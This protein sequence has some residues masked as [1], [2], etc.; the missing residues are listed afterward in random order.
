MKR[1][2]PAAL[3]FF[4]AFLL[5]VSLFSCKQA[6]TKN[7]S[8]KDSLAIRKEY[9]SSPV[10]SPDES[11]KQIQ[12]EKG[13]TVKLV[14]SEPVVNS[15]VALTFDE[16][17]R[18]WVAEML[19]YMPDTV[20][21]G[22]ERPTGKI[23]I[24]SDRNGDGVMD[25]QKMFLDSL[26]LPRAL[27]L[28]DNGILVAESPKLWFYEIENDRPVKKTLVDSAYAEGGNVE[29]QPN[30]LL[31]ALDNWIYNAK[32]AKRYRK[33]GD[34][35]LIER[36]H[37]RGQW[38]ITQDD[39][40][41][42][43]YN[44]NSENLLG[45][46]FTPGVG[47]YNK[48]QPQVAGFNENIV[49]DNRVYPIRPNTG[50]NRGY[51]EGILNSSLRLV[52]FTAACGPAYYDAPLFGKDFYGSVFVAEPSANLIKRDVL[53]D[54]GYRVEGKQAYDNREFL[55][56][57]DERFRPVSLYEG[58][59]GA[60]YVADMYRGI[61]QH[62][63]FLTGYLKN[64][65]KERSLTLP[66]NYGRI[67][68]VVPENAKVEKVLIDKDP[69][70]LVALLGSDNGWI[71]NKAQQLLIDGKFTQIEPDVRNLLKQTNKPLTLIHALWA[72]EGLNVLQGGD[73]LPLLQQA[74]WTIRM[75]A[76]SVLPS[77][78]K[79]NNFG[80]FLRIFDKMIDANDTLAAPY[81][82]FLAHSIKPYDPNAA[83]RI[84]SALIKK[85][86]SNIYVADAVIS[87]LE[88]KENEY[89]KKLISSPADTG[90]AIV[91]RLKLVIENIAKTKNKARMKEVEK[92]FPKGAALFSSTCQPCH[93]SDGNGVRALGPPLNNSNWVLGDK[94]K[95][96]PIVLFGLTGPV[97]V[98]DKLYK[99]PEVSGEMPAIGQNKEFTDEDIAQVLSF[100]RNGWNNKAAPIKA[101]DVVNAR[102]KF[103]GR[104]K[105]FTPD[106]LDK[107]R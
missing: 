103:K 91:K 63:A 48:N 21:T 72:M 43:F 3:F 12:A 40:G 98:G 10:L 50:V 11:L 47:A 36:T 8:E 95:L 35:W 17:G 65:I 93:G 81:L 39:Q 45:D 77:I 69:R 1:T 32:S 80:Q 7:N 70:Q 58:P 37:F 78:L 97:K 25:E 66:L 31:R 29:H 22:E 60:L 4:A 75:Q 33:Q 64:E 51:M 94:N 9:A 20:G 56:S 18:I 23:V 62:K 71:R 96:L 73:V 61:I 6:S 106:E 82:G 15:P 49:P 59:D 79:T 87:N 90:L 68:K 28:I 13:F 27:C 57:K 101:S 19:S 105:S 102:N 92:Q 16:K 34:K 44:T 46:Y 2:T 74:D 52:N 99:A 107:L 76:L 38:G 26:V 104:Q 84:L 88:N 41:R 14:A 89:L 54:V 42:L 5:L 55:A 67:Y 100:I 53:K 85:Y 30:G 86:P 83:N 24:L